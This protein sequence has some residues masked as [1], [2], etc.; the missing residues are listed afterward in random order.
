[1][2]EGY[3]KAG[4]KAL[5]PFHTRPLRESLEMLVEAK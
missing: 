2:T 4:K 3:A 1:M 5:D